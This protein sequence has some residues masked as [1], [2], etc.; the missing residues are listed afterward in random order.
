MRSADLWPRIKAG[1]V[2]LMQADPTLSLIAGGIKS[3]LLA[4]TSNIAFPHV[5]ATYDGL[6]ERFIGGDSETI[7]T[8]Y[9]VRCIIRDNNDPTKVHDKA[10]LYQSWRKA[11]TDLFWQRT[12]TD[13]IMIQGAP[14]V[15]KVTLNL[16]PAIDPRAGWYPTM[17]SALDVLCEAA[18]ARY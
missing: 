17:V 9:P 10:D 15:Y 8:E 7:M 2:A 6:Q 5:V 16:K 1:I 14:E 11:L 18:E 3:Q 4:D 13:G 12:R